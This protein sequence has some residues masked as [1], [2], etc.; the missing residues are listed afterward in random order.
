MDMQLEAGNYSIIVT[1]EKAAKPNSGSDIDQAPPIGPIAVT[2]DYE[3]D[4]APFL[5]QVGLPTSGKFEV[6]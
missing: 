6:Y 5:G 2:W 1:L 4:T 3:N